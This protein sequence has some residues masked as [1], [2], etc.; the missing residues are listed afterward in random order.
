MTSCYG[1]DES[2]FMFSGRKHGE[3]LR[4]S[5]P[6]TCAANSPHTLPDLTIDNRFDLRL[7]LVKALHTS[8]VFLNT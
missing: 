7:K 1:R 6:H 3:L 8:S 5:L 4:F 2:V